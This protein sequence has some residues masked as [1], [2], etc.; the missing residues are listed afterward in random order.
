MGIFK[1]KRI[2]DFS[3]GSAKVTGG[4]PGLQIQCGALEPSQVSSIL[5]HFRQFIQNAADMLRC[6][7]EIFK[8][9]SKTWLTTDMIL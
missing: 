9:A 6:Y 2:L 3:E 5:M 8:E 4:P 1:V 7:Q